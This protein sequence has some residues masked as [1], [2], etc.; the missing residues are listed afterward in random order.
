MC[1]LTVMPAVRGDLMGQLTSSV[2]PHFTVRRDLVLL[3]R[4]TRQIAARVAEAALRTALHRP[5]VFFHQRRCLVESLHGGRVR[6]GHGA[7]A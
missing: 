5:L 7:S 3:Q 4:L 1:Y 2:I 6:A